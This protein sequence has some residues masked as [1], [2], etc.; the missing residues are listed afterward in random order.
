MT[1]MKFLSARFERMGW[2]R[3]FD[4]A[5]RFLNGAFFMLINEVFD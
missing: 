3:F 4:D 5:L 1:N 2:L